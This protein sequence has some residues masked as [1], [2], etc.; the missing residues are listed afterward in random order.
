MLSVENLQ[1]DD[2][3][4][5]DKEGKDDKK[6]AKHKS[7]KDQKAQKKVQK[8]WLKAKFAET[9]AAKVS[10]KAEFEARRN[11]NSFVVSFVCFA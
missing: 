4:G 2:A 8:A 9:A 1:T 11:L 7:Q 5:C 10:S 3:P 6:H